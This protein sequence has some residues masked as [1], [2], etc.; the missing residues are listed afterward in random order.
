MWK[1]RNWKEETS[2]IAAIRESVQGQE[3]R[4]GGRNSE[5]IEKEE[6]KKE[7]QTEGGEGQ[8]RVTWDSVRYLDTSGKDIRGKDGGFESLCL[9]TPN[10]D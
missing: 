10:Q 9:L 8:R 6:R 1:K 5:D 4:N 7:R 2:R 3:F